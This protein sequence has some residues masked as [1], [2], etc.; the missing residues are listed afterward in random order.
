MILG[1]WGYGPPVSRVIM[2]VEAADKLMT[3]GTNSDWV[4]TQG[5]VQMNDEYNGEDYDARNE[6]EVCDNNIIPSGK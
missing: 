3:F 4:M 6:T 1:H 5:P 2:T